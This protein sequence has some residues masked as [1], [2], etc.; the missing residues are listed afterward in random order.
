MLALLPRCRRKLRTGDEGA[1]GEGGGGEGERRL[2]RRRLGERVLEEGQR[3]AAR[4]LQLLQRRHLHQRDVQRCAPRN[5]ERAFSVR[6]RDEARGVLCEESSWHALRCRKATQR[7]ATGR[8]TGAPAPA[9]MPA[10]AAR[11]A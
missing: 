2:Q 10:A 1:E 6:K 3:V 8:P 11:G 4:V 5:N 9:K 7:E